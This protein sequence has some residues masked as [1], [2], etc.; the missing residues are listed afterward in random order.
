MRKEVA[1]AL[2]EAWNEQYPIGTKVI[3]IHD[4]GERL[5]VITNGA[6]SA[7][8]RVGDEASAMVSVTTGDPSKR[9]PRGPWLLER[10][11]PIND[12]QNRGESDGTR[13]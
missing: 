7:W 9:F 8:Q 10:C 4:H 6:A 11:I 5:E 12:S 2:V 13:N 1:E 3:L